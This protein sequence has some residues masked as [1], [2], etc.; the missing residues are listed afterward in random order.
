MERASR[1]ILMYELVEESWAVY[2]AARAGSTKAIT[3]S[4]VRRSDVIPLASRKLIEKQITIAIA[5]LE[6]AKSHLDHETTP[7]APHPSK[8][9]TPSG[10]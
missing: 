7:A 8:S 6:K 3:S 1:Q 4:D 9:K 10:V 5:S 2:K